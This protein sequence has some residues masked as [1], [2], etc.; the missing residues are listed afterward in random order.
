MIFM[1]LLWKYRALLQRYTALSRKSRALSQKHR[2]LLRM[3]G[4][5]MKTLA[6]SVVV[7][8][9]RGKRRKGFFAGKKKE[10]LD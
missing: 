4:P 7:G 10:K 8:P 6:V 2:A 1:A 5:Y 3:T 9:L